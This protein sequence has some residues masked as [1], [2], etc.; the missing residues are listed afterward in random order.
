MKNNMRAKRYAP[1][2]VGGT[3]DITKMKI[4][5]LR[6]VSKKQDQVFALLMQSVL[7]TVHD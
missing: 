3:L 6:K 4:I 2:R 7:E 1:K 5:R